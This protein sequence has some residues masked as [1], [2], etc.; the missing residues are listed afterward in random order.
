MFAVATRLSVTLATTSSREFL[1]FS[2]NWRHTFITA[3][4]LGMVPRLLGL[5]D[6]LLE[7][8]ALLVGALA[9]HRLHRLLDVH[10]P[11]ICHCLHSNA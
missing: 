10:N 5:L 2:L 6:H 7:A 1:F 11:L 8:K 4:L 3:T 9:L